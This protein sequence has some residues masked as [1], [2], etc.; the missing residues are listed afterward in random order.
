MRPSCWPRAAA[1]S[2]PPGRPGRAP[3]RS[4]EL[5]ADAERATAIGSRA[6]AYSREHDLVGG[7]RRVP[8]R[9]SLAVGVASRPRPDRPARTGAAVAGRVA[10]SEPCRA[11]PRCYPGQPRAPRRADRPARDHAARDRAPSP[12]RPTATAPTTSSR[13]LQVDLLHGRTL[14]WPAVAERPGERPLPARTRSTR[15]SAGSGTSGEPTAHG[16]T[17]PP[18]RTATGRAMLALGAPSPDHRRTAGWSRGGLALHRRAAGGRPRDR[19][20][21]AG[22]GAPRVRR[23]DPGDPSAT[24]ATVRALADAGARASSA[25]FAHVRDR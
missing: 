8:A 10:R 20:A 2:S 6:Y 23:R 21:R 11:Q 14:G 16:S 17:R 7:R 15:R 18:P 25:T 24:D 19:A 5:L 9:S 13:A 3:R 22:L 4:T 12:T 1:S